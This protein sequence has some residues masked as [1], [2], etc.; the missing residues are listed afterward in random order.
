MTDEIKKMLD[1]A[2]AQLHASYGPYLQDSEQAPMVSAF[3]NRSIASSL[4]AI[5][6]MMEKDRRERRKMADYQYDINFKKKGV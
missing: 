5:A 4:L 2:E 6:T 1:E 3:V